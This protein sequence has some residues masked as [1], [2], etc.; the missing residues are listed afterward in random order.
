MKENSTSVRTTASAALVISAVLGPLLAGPQISGNHIF[1]FRILAP[2]LLPVL[3]ISVLL[4]EDN[5][6]ILSREEVL[7]YIFAVYL[8]FLL[9]T[10]PSV[11]DGLSSS[12]VVLLPIA[13]GIVIGANIRDREDLNIHFM[14]LIVLLFIGVIIAIFEMSSGYHLPTSRIPTLT[15]YHSQKASAWYFNRNNL[16]AFLSIIF[17]LIF[18]KMLY[19][20]GYQRIFSILFAGNICMITY[21]NGSRGAQL[22]IIAASLACGVIFLF[23]QSLISIRSEIS[24]LLSIIPFICLIVIGT[25]IIISENLIIDDQSIFIRWQLLRIAVNSASSTLLGSGLGGFQDIVQQSSINTFG[26][27]TPHSWLTWLL[28]VT[29]IPGT[30]I[31]L[32]LLGTL[33]QQNFNR[34][35]TSNDPVYLITIGVIISFCISGIS[36]SNVLHMEGIW[37]IIAV[38]TT[39]SRTVD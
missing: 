27:L 13:S 1:L 29:G 37:I 25:V 4:K 19:Q 34:Y 17:P 33:L 2:V 24:S 23:R 22:G 15:G 5:Q 26:I 8:V 3:I 21:L 6:L 14:I 35:I 11:T 20:A 30:F 18:V 10:T 32:A 38:L 9:S 36:P 39:V 12:S 16:S 7:F 28:A 31:F